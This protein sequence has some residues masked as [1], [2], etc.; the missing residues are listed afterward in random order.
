MKKQLLT[1]L[2]AVFIYSSNAQVTLMGLSSHGGIGNHGAIFNVTSTS[3]F[4]TLYNYNDGTNGCSPEGSMIQ[5][6]DGNFYGLTA[7][8]GANSVGTLFRYNPN[9]KVITTL[10]DFDSAIG[11]GPM[12]TLVQATDGYLYGMTNSGGRYGDGTIFKCSMMGNLTVVTN[13]ADYN[14]AFPLGNLVEAPDGNFYGMTRFGGAYGKGTIFK[15][16]PSGAL[17][18]LHSFS[19]TD[20]SEPVASLTI[21]KDSFLYGLTYNGGLYNG[22]VV[23]Y[24]STTGT[25]KM[26]TSLSSTT[27]IFPFGSFFNPKN[28]Y[29]YAT[30][31]YGGS[32]FLGTLIRCDDSG[33]VVDIADFNDTNGAYPMGSLMRASD[34][35]LY[36]TTSHGGIPGVNNGVV[37]SYNIASQILSDVYQ[38]TALDPKNPDGDLIEISTVTTGSKTIVANKSAKIYPNPNKGQ[39]TLDL[40]NNEVTINGNDNIRM[41]VYNMLGQIVFTENMNVLQNSNAINLGSQPTGLYLYKVVSDNSGLLANGKFVIE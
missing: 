37:F 23:F 19:G 16:T 27:G 30:T 40:G 28:G 5:A 20:G 36:G 35:K 8:C 12:G 34:G 32:Y 3:T 10:V 41:E 6:T 14:G 29:L 15:C 1:I 25:F 21:I 13:F 2:I 26:L 38:L 24:C 17:T 33:K 9:T 39:F 11:G 22:G 31:S 18:L 7:S 4:D